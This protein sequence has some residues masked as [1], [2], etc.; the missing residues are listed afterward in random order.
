MKLLI[1]NRE[2][3]WRMKINSSTQE[4]NKEQPN[5]SPGI[6]YDVTQ[7]TK[8]DVW[9]IVVLRMVRLFQIRTPPLF[10]FQLFYLCSSRMVLKFLSNS[11]VNERLHEFVQPAIKTSSGS[12]VHND[13]NTTISWTTLTVIEVECEPE[14]M[15][16]VCRW[17]SRKAFISQTFSGHPHSSSDLVLP[18]TSFISIATQRQ[19][20]S[21]F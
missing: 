2:W 17:N 21:F 14:S 5:K 18:S 12:I 10:S 16:V 1:G 20:R 7:V 3:I 8:A 6:S 15:N 11:S 9:E 13:N 4:T 19:N